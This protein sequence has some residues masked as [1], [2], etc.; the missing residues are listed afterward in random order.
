MKPGQ[1]LPEN[2][3]V[4]NGLIWLVTE[5]D[6]ARATVRLCGGDLVE[7]TPL[8]GLGK[9]LDLTAGTVQPRKRLSLKGPTSS[10]EKLILQG[11]LQVARLIKLLAW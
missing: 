6:V 8:T 11:R 1:V 2:S 4:Y 5:D 9:L 7:V 10:R 3:A